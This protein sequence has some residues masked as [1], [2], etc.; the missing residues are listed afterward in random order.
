MAGYLLLAV[1]DLVIGFALKRYK[2]CKGKNPASIPTRTPLYLLFPRL[3]VR[4]VCLQTAFELNLLYNRR[5]PSGL[6]YHISQANIS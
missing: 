1:G 3:Y 4:H 2:E 5:L 6:T